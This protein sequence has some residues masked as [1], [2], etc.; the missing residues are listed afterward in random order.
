MDISEELLLEIVKSNR[1]NIKENATLNGR[2]E[3]MLDKIDRG[4]VA[5]IRINKK[6]DRT[7]EI[8]GVTIFFIFVILFCDPTRV[9]SVVKLLKGGVKF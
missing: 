5:Y 2:I 1:E 3:L 7:R 9:M 6:L 4:D 8:L